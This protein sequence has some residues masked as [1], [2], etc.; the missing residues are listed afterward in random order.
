MVTPEGELQGYDEKIQR[1][2]LFMESLKKIP[3]HDISWEAQVMG[4]H[5]KGRTF[6]YHREEPL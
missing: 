1:F 4:Q 3:T 5:D 2:Q 6:K